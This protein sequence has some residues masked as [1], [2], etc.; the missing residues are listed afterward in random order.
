MS[1]QS[2]RLEFSGPQGS[3][4]AAQHPKSTVA[5]DGADHL[6]T[7]IAEGVVVVSERGKGD[8]AQNVTIGRH[9]LTA[10]EPRPIGTDT[11]QSAYDFLPAGE[12]ARAMEQV[13]ADRLA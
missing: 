8:F 4:L 10:D 13:H 6:L 5:L 9:R 12:G 1:R 2:E 11:G 3:P 7:K